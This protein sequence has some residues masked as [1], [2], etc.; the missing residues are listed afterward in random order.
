MRFAGAAAI[1]IL[2]C[3]CVLPAGAQQDACKQRTIPVSLGSTDGSP[4]PALDSSNFEGSYKNKPVRVISAVMNQEP[5]RVVLL[6]DTSSS[7]R[8]PDSGPNWDHMMDVGEVIALNM[9]SNS[10]VGLGFFGRTL[11]P[12]LPPTTDRKMLKYHLQALRSDRK[13]YRERTAL[14]EAIVGSVKMFDHPHVGDAIY[15]I[16]DG[17]DNASKITVNQVSQT[18]FE[19]GVRLF[20]GLCNLRSIIKVSDR[21]TDVLRITKDAGGAAVVLSFEDYSAA[22]FVDHVP[23]LV[24][25][26]GKPTRLGLDLSSQYRQMIDFYRVNI[27]LPEAV[28]KPGELKLGLVGID[29]PQRNKLVLTYPRMLV[30]CH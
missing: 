3:L 18:L 22:G 21:Q 27:E 2:C 6:L 7:M 30:P 8:D 11:I 15:V 24:D 13:V 4:I 9:P 25:K 14:W 28:E 10:G 16:T 12:A 20:T 19:S 29:K 23:T 26:S 5:P 17:D 1:S